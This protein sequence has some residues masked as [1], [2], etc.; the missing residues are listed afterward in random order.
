MWRYGIVILSVGTLLLAGCEEKKAPVPPVVEHKIL[1]E[2]ATDIEILDSIAKTVEKGAA[3]LVSKQ[4]PDGSFGSMPQQAVGITGLAVTALANC[5]KE[6]REKYK[7]AIDK[8]CKF[9]L[10][11]QQSDGSILDPE[12]GF[13]VYKTSVSIMALC[14]A[15]RTG[16][17]DWIKKAQD[18]IVRSQY[19]SG[20]VASDVKYGGWG[21]NEKEQKPAADL[22]NTQF[23]LEASEA[24]G[25][26]KDNPV[27]ERAVKFVSRSQQW[28]ETNDLAGKIEK[29]KIGND[30][31]FIY[32]PA[33]TR[34]LKKEDLP[35][36]EEGNTIFT[37]YAS[38]TYAGF[39][40][41]LYANVKRTDPRVQAAWRWICANYTLD[42][43]RGMGTRQEPATTKQGLYY[44]YRAFGRALLAWG[45]RTITDTN[46]VKHDWCKELAA[47]IA[48]LQRPDG[49]WVNEA[50]KWFEGLPELVISYALD[51][52]NM[53]RLQVEKEKK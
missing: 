39:K 37:S 19:W 20:I 53:A 28:T 27:W 46:N 44:F 10:S 40:S 26:L 41:L 38:M 42:E 47:K 52:L 8:G 36:D 49:S 13:A 15:D 14:S 6:L 51:A 43:N 24:Y 2:A 4:Q 34:A 1:S 35:K 32:G 50:D 30:G 31:G 9:L 17:A 16:Y 21:Y 33:D 45:E 5:S 29:V 11:R 23:A 7:D 25:L 48:S 12:Q 3:F 22:S 18:Y